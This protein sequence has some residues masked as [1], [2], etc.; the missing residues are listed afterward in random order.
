MTGWIVSQGQDAFDSIAHYA[1]DLRLVAEH[2]DGE[3]IATWT[4]LP[5]H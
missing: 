5:H 2:A 4:E 1:E 3:V